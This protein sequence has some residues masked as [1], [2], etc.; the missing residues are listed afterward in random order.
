VNGRL[1]VIAVKREAPLSAP[2]LEFDL[3]ECTEHVSIPLDDAMEQGP[4][5]AAL[6]AGFIFHMSRT[7]STVAGVMLRATDEIAFVSEPLAVNDLMFRDDPDDDRLGAQLQFIIDWFVAALGGSRRVVFKFASWVSL[8][9]DRFQTLYP[10]VPSAFMYRE[11]VEVVSAVVNSAPYMFRRE[12]MRKQ[13]AAHAR[14]K[15]S[16]EKRLN[17]S[18]R[19]RVDYTRE[20]SYVE[21]VA[22]FIG[23]VC[24]PP[25]AAYAS[26]RSILPVDYATFKEQVVEQLAPRFGVAVDKRKRR[27]MLDATRYNVKALRPPI[28]FQN[29]SSFKRQAATPLMSEMCDRFIQPSIDILT[30]RT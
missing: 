22:R 27:L 18:L 11:P 1:H 3:N 8:H 23:V 2:F 10:T 7:G 30:R 21:F 9:L 29:D 26:T 15:S 5:R 28:V 17:N 14:E 24:E 6:P 19:G 20:C 4:R 12:S 13:F 16:F 25:A